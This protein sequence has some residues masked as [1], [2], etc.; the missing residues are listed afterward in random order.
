M[1]RPEHP[2]ALLVDDDPSVLALYSLYLTRK[3]FQV[4]TAH[5]GG[6][7]LRH[8]KFHPE[9]D[10]V[11]TDIYMPD[12]DGIELSKK[13]H[14]HFPVLVISSKCDKEDMSK[15]LDTSDAYLDKINLISDIENAI[16]KAIIRWL[17]EPGH[18]YMIPK[19][20]S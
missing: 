6:E 19:K 11:I 14:D 8:V 3:G 10:I 16:D 20:A 12:V 13:L 15:I 5:N 2:K 17:R 9:I 4:D 18:H 7:A 1:R